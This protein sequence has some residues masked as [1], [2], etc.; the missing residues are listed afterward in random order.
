METKVTF[1]KTT[2]ADFYGSGYTN[3][4]EYK[5]PEYT[6]SPITPTSNNVYVHN[7]VFRSCSSTSGGGAI[8][9]HSSNNV[10]RLLVIRSSF[11]TCKSSSQYGG[12]IYFY[13]STSGECILSK[14]CGF[15]CSLTYSGTSTSWG[16]FAF[17]YIK[18]GATYK[19]HVND[20][21]FA[22]SLKEGLYPREVLCLYYSNILCPSVNITN[23]ECCYYTA[24]YCYPTASPEAC[25]ISYSTIVN[26]TA[27]GGYSCIFLSSSSST[28]LIDK[29]NIL[30]NNQTSTS[31]SYGTIYTEVSLF[32][33][34]SCILGNNKGY[35]VFSCSGSPSAKI[36][37]SNCTID[38]DTISNGRYSG[39]LTISKTNERIFINALSH[40]VTQ[41]CDSYFDSYGTLTGKP[42]VPSI[43]SLCLMSCVCKDPII[44]PLRIIKFIFLLTF[45]PSDQANA[46]YFEFNCIL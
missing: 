2:F 39:T 28:Q 46:A 8:Y 16:P 25:C 38:N 45:L 9:C 30:N 15:N 41:L 31:S 44:G 34:D 21:S 14:I 17:T 10:L 27:N 23:N 19:N 40:I 20:S 42:N 7:S 22:H 24:L 37:I 18:S 29:C 1:L 36:T 11:M 6:V 32:I 33:K 12:G 13:S 35:N 26:N 5:G 3:I 43:K 4:Q